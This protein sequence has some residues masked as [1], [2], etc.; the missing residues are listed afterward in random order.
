MLAALKFV[1]SAFFSLHFFL[2]IGI[3]GHFQF[4]IIL[5]IFHILHTHKASGRKCV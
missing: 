4:Y 5:F 1:V 3:V 2:K